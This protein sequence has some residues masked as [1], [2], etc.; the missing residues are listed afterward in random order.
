MPV[1]SGEFKD[2][3]GIDDF[4]DVAEG[5]EFEYHAGFHY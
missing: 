3:A 2:A 1:F 5:V 4:P